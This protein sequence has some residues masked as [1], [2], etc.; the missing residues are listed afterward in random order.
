MRIN[1]RYNVP[2]TPDEVLAA[3]EEW[4]RAD[5]PSLIPER[6]ASDDGRETVSGSVISDVTEISTSFTAAPNSIGTDLRVQIA[7]RGIGIKGKLHQLAM[8]P[9]RGIVKD[10]MRQQMDAFTAQWQVPTDS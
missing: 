9:S 10:Y 3:A 1:F 2:A 6:L 4:L 5:S 7:M 8:M